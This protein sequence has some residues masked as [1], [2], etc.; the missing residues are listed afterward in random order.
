MARLSEHRSQ[1]LGEAAA[2]EGGAQ[3][4][5]GGGMVTTRWD[6]ALSFLLM[7]ALEAYE[8]VQM[9]RAEAR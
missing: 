6:A 5:G 3:G 4:K 2:R 7:P 1:A 9:T 8:Q